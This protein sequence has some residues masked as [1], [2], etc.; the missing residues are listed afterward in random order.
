MNYDSLIMN[1][2]DW[3]EVVYKKGVY[4]KGVYE[5]GVYE[6]GV[7]DWLDDLA[8]KNQNFNADINYIQNIRYLLGEIDSEKLD[9]E[10]FIPRKIS[11]SEYETPVYIFAHPDVLESKPETVFWYLG[12]AGIAQKTLGN[13][14]P[15]YEQMGGKRSPKS[16]SQSL[17]KGKSVKR[18][19]LETFCIWLNGKISD[20][21]D[22]SP[23][24]VTDFELKVAM[25]LG[26]R[27]IGKGQNDT[28]SLAVKKL[29]TQ[30]H[31]NPGLSGHIL[32]FYVNNKPQRYSSDSFEELLTKSENSINCICFDNGSKIKFP[33]GGDVPDILFLLKDNKPVMVGEIKGRKDESNRQESW[34][35]Q[36]EAHFKSW[37]DEF[38][39]AKRFALGTLI[40]EEMLSAKSARGTTVPNFRKMYDDGLLHYVVNINR[41]DNEE[42]YREKVCQIFG[43]LLELSE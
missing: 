32:K 35:P 16:L 38:P 10:K 39:D 21:F 6:K 25:V 13:I 23:V 24:K 31:L 1:E 29:I 37:Q 20:S 4:E 2:D 9:W 36:M 12:G 28:G 8:R 41:L 27:A 42:E 11:L 26:G 3:D 7:K 17:G 43:T 19:E 22:K 33:T 18:K 30:F 40:S 14:R 5:R 34:L 15:D